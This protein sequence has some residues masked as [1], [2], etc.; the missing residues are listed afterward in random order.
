MWRVEGPAVGIDLGTTFSRVAHWTGD[1]VEIIRNDQGNRTTPSC[2]AFTD[3]GRLIGES[4]ANQ[5]ELDPHNTVFAAKRLIGRRFADPSVQADAKLWPFKVVSSREGVAVIQ[6][7]HKGHTKTFMPEEIS[8][9]VLVK[10]KEAAEAHLG[11]AVPNVVISVPAY[12]NDG[13]RQATKDAGYIAGLNVL[14]IINDTA[15]VALAYELGLHGR[16]PSPTGT[17]GLYD[18]RNVLIFDLGGGTFDVT[19]LSIE[20]GIF[21]V[22]ATAGDTHLGGEDFDNR[23]VNHFVAEFKRKNRGQDPAGD[24]HALRRLRT[25]CERAKRMLSSSH[26]VTIEIDSFFEGVD[27]FTSISRARFEELNADLFPRC[28]EGVEKVLHDSKIAKGSVHDIVLVGGSTRIPM[29]RSMLSNFFDGKQLCC[30]LNTGEA[31][32]YGAAVQAAILSD[33][34]GE[35]LDTLG[36][37]LLVDVVAHSL[38][39]ETRSLEKPGGVM[40]TLICRNTA[41]PTKRCDCYDGVCERGVRFQVFE[42][43]HKEAKENNKLGE[44]HV[45]SL[46]IWKVDVTFDIDANGVMR[47]GARPGKGQ[48]TTEGWV[49]VT[50]DKGR[51]SLDDI[52]RMRRATERFAA[53][54]ETQRAEFRRH[55][56]L[57]RLSF[58][59]TLLPSASCTPHSGVVELP[60]ELCQRIGQLHFEVVSIL[61]QPTVGMRLPPAARVSPTTKVLPGHVAAESAEAEAE[62]LIVRRLRSDLAAEPEPEPEPELEPWSRGELAIGGQNQAPSALARTL[63]ARERARTAAA[64]ALASSLEDEMASVTAEMAE[65]RA[66]IL[67]ARAE[68]DH[69]NKRG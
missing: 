60:V 61:R 53:E 1:R 6:V 43:E 31:V 28:M 62:A 16:W 54:D 50:N 37:I 45:D 35:K 57:Q 42:G 41:I 67:V 56:A 7:K 3:R 47:V 14:R 55:A 9:M 33:T 4:A 46:G 23:M 68:V 69:V 65:V 17:G 20:D 58:A 30:E 18:E 39:L 25:A 24:A 66:E 26:Q 40:T 8:S 5:C 59:S 34:G 38:S 11:V 13:Q 19:L 15:A 2:V 36:D 29:V 44:F 32:A 12:F 48:P 63:S 21:E 52:E 49:Q 22:K 27:L 64:E 10:M 51:G